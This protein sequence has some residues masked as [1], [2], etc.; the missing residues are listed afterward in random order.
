[1]RRRKLRQLCL[2]R[3]LSRRRPRLALGRLSR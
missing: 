2:K 1:L 3:Q